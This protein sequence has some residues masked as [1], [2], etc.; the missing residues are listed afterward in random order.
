MYYIY[1]QALRTLRTKQ[2]LTPGIIT[3]L[4]RQE[5]LWYVLWK[6]HAVT[7]R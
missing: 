1:R 5:R 6:D 4:G 2:L 3:N 7:E